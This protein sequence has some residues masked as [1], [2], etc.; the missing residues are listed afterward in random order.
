MVDRAGMAEVS[1]LGQYNSCPHAI[2][3]AA[4]H[5]ERVK[6]MVLFGGAGAGLER[7]ER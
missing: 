3:F 2:A 7:D 1:L 6:R 5:P 4:R